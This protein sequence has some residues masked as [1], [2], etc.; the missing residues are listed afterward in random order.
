MKQAIVITAYK[1]FEQL[2]KLVDKLI[3]SFNIYIHI[4]L[5]SKSIQKS[6][7]KYLEKIGCIVIKRY[8]INWG[9]YNHLNAIIDL[10]EIA[11]KDESNG[12]FHIISGEDFPVRDSKCIIDYFEKNKNNIYMSVQKVSEDIKR[13]KYRYRYLFPTD[14]INYKT[15]FGKLK[16]AI[17]VALQKIVL[18]KRC[19]IGKFNE[20]EIYKG[21]VYIS[22]Y[23]EALEYVLNYI[24]S[25]KNYLNDLKTCFIAEEF[26]FQTIIM[27][28]KYK[29]RVVY[30][31]LRYVDWTQKNG[32]KPAILDEG[33]Y[34]KIINGEYIFMR[35]IGSC[36]NELLKKLNLE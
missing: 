34:D 17:T 1:N 8:S 19:N 25:D 12:Y 20:D 31:N 4:D 10:L 13:I 26:F 21:L 14:I 30:K 27:N 36:S 6:E 15:R 16:W 7:I 18:F 5:K 35:K 32:S 23:K 24:K 3:D 22:I 28:S 11:I 33:D 2:K 9:G 29:D